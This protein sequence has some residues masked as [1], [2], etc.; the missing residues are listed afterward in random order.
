[1]RTKP[2]IEPIIIRSEGSRYVDIAM[3]KYSYCFCCYICTAKSKIGYLKFYNIN[4]FAAN[5]WKKKRRRI[6]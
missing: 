3:V 5:G 6:F 1:M 4:P 2:V